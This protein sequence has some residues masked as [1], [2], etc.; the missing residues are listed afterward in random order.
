MDPVT[1]AIAGAVATGVATGAGEGVG[2]ALSAFV[3]RIRAR[4]TGRES[5]LETTESAAEALDA[6][7]AE[8][9]EFRRECHEEWDRIGG[10]VTNNFT[11][12][13]RTVIQARDVHGGLT[14]N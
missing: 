5:A 4:F 13:A 9:P 8:D 7:F 6:E 2:T 10:A 3:G 12:Q 14:I 11:G 1:L